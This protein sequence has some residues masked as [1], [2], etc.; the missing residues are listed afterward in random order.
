LDNALDGRSL[1]V[2][3]DRVELSKNLIR[4]FLAFDE[5]LASSPR[6]RGRVVFL[7]RV[8]ASRESLPAYLAY[9]TEVENV[10]ARVNQRWRTP[11][12]TPVVLDLEDDFAATVAALQRYELLVVNPV[13]DGLNL[14][15]MEGPAINERDG[16]LVLSREAGS[17]EE[18]ADLAI[19][20]NPFDVTATAAALER[21]LS[22]SG[23]ERRARAGEMRRRT[24]ARTPAQWLHEVHRAAR[25]ASS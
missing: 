21:G 9:R 18:L 12:Y 17:Y 4:G 13:R 6:W 5:F 11:G 1:V 25:V 10:V 14:V 3:S 16:A 19:G 23:E 24:R 2:R 15:A 22:M 20:V 8:Y 7:A